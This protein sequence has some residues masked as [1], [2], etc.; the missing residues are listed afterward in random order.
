MLSQPLL[1]QLLG[2]GV[3]EWSSLV[4]QRHY[5]DLFAAFRSEPEMGFEPMTCALRGPVK[6][7]FWVLLGRRLS[8]K[9]R[10]TWVKVQTMAIRC[11]SL[12]RMETELL[13]Q[14]FLP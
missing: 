9:R 14:E 3:A 7:S 4:S 5:Q 12:R 11:N 2:Q 13:G 6:A 1:E 10:S 8:H